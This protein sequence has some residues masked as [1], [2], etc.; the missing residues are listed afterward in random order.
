MYLLPIS[1]FN[2]IGYQ[3]ENQ[4]HVNEENAREFSDNVD[5][6]GTEFSNT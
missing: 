5:E 2:I 1:A 4:S 3:K 6:S